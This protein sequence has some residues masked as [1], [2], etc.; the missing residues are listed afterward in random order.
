MLAYVRSVGG[1]MHGAR[2]RVV[3]SLLALA[4][5]A[6]AQGSRPGSAPPAARAL[7]PADTIAVRTIGDLAIAPDGTR[8]AFAGTTEPAPRPAPD[9]LVVTRLQYKTRTAFSDNRR[10]H[11]FVVSAT[12]RS[13]PKPL[14]VGDFDNHSLDWGG[15]G[16][17]IVFLSNRER[18]PDASLNYDIYAVNVSTGAL[19]QVTSTPGVEM[20]PVVSPDGKSIAYL[21]TTRPVTTIDSV[22][23]DAHVFVVPVAGGAPRELN[24]ALDRRSASPAWTPDST[25]VLFTAGDHGKALI[26]RVPAA[27][28]ASKAVFDRNAQASGLSVARDGTI[29]FG[30]TDL[31][32]PRELFRLPPGAAQPSQITKINADLLAQWKL[33][34]PE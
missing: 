32:M 5:T 19:R 11:V 29:V 21:A 27:G 8:L 9:P 13:T 4:L 2:T 34:R 17:E 6:G 23:E 16:S 15:D 33:V 3:V 30:M 14:T 25:S 28:G 10:S 26:Y 18:D 31:Q 1:L 22:A 20:D 7:A 12:D 24:Q